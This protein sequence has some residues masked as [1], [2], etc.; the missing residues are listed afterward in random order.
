MFALS[1]DTTALTE[2]LDYTN[3]LPLHQEVPSQSA[4]MPLHGKTT[5]EEF[6]PPAET[7]LI[8]AF[9]WSDIP[10]TETL[11]LIGSSETLGEIPGERTDSSGSKS[12]KIYAQS[13]TTPPSSLLPLLKSIML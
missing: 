11:E 10:T 9:N 8:T 13:E 7:V 12:D 3:K 1:L 5:T 6:F 4:L 2:K